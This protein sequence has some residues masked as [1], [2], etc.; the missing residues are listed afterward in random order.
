MKCPVCK[1]ENCKDVSVRKHNGVLGLGASC[2]VSKIEWV[3]NDC[4]VYF[5]PVNQ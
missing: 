5:K 2:V 1:S 4:G 3:C